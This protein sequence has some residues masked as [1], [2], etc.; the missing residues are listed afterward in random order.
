MDEQKVDAEFTVKSSSIKFTVEKDDKEYEF[1]PI[2]EVT[3]LVKLRLDIIDIMKRFNITVKCKNQV[4]IPKSSVISSRTL[5]DDYLRAK[6]II[7]DWYRE[8]PE[9][10]WSSG[11]LMEAAKFQKARRTQIM[12]RLL[13]KEK[14]IICVN[15]Q[16]SRN[17]RRY[18]KAEAMVTPEAIVEHDMKKL[19]Q[20][21]KL[22][23]EG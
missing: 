7:R 6:D 12:N 5:E 9:K 18:V 11:E 16:F 3:D 19:E 23:R 13:K 2:G 20:E 4:T 17:M 22:V 8:D 14:F 21:R 15:P 10:A 1:E